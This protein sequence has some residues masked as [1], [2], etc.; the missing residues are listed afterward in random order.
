[1]GQGNGG[2]RDRHHG[3]REAVRRVLGQRTGAQNSL[4]KGKGKGVQNS[5][6]RVPSVHQ[7]AC[8]ALPQPR[9]GSFSC[10]AAEKIGTMRVGV[11]V[12]SG[13]VKGVGRG[14]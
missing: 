3:E 1:M 6:G 8:H 11:G 7:F 10:S 13:V 2:G 9:A 4:G 14:V 5:W 12:G